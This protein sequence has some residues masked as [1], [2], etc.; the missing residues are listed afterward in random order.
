MT[1]S[2]ALQTR[3]GLDEAIASAE[4]EFAGLDPSASWDACDQSMK[5]KFYK[6][7]LLYMAKDNEGVKQVSEGGYSI[8]YDKDDKARLLQ[9]IAEESGCSE[10]IEKFTVGVVKN[11][12][13]LW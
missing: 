8:T 6:A 9:G 4:L 13:N 7:M 1:L 10:L 11:K 2:F 3:T 12:S 5:C